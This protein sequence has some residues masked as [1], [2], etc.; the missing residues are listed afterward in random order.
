[1]PENAGHDE[2]GDFFV[3]KSL[4]LKT[5]E[6]AETKI[7][8]FRKLNGEKAFQKA[9]KAGQYKHPHSMFFGGFK[10]TWSR[11][12]LEKIIEKHKLFS[13]QVVAI[14]DF[15][16]GLGPFGYGEPIS[17]HIPGT[18]GFNW[19][20]SA[21][22]DSLGVPEMGTSSSIPLYGTARDLWDRVLINRYAYI[23]LEYGTY[24]QEQSRKALR[25]EHWLHNQGCLLY[26]SDAADE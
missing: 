14:I 23:A 21:Y 15:H 8:Q 13:R 26:T 10:P 3:P 19:V 24:S 17:G 22:G 9:R 6:I 4:D 1:M 12:T 5:L 20:S 25:E 11:L 16:T 7:A 2:L 18:F